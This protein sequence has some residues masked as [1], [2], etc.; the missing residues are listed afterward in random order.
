MLQK[1]I[2]PDTRRISGQSIFSFL[3]NKEPVNVKEEE[4]YTSN[5]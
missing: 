3:H 4:N 2:F 1:I 5:A